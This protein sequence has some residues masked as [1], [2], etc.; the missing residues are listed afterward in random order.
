MSARIVWAVVGGFLM[1]VFAASFFSLGYTFALFALLLATLAGLFV[2]V[3]TE[4]RNA[5]IVAVVV[6]IAFAAGT[7]RM[8]G[9]VR[10]EDATLSSHL[11]E[12]VT[13]SGIVSQ[14][15][16]KRE[17]NTRLTIDVDTM[18]Y[19]S[20]ESEVDAKILVIAPLRTEAK[21]GDTVEV[22]GELDRPEAF[23][24]TLG[25]S[26]DYPKYLAK[27]GILYTLSFA[28]VELL[29]ENYANPAKAFAIGIKQLFL[30]GL[31]ASIPEPEAGLAGGITVGDKRSIGEELTDDFIATS[32]IH[33]VVLSGYN[34]TIV[35]NSVNAFA[36]HAPSSAR[37]GIAGVI[38]ALFALMSG[39]AATAV[40]AGA[41]ALIAIYAR[42][43][44]RTFLA[45]RALGVVCMAMV[46]WNPWTLAFDPSFQLSALATLGLIL[47]T[48]IFAS[49]LHRVPKRWGMREILAST[50]ATQIAV[51]P[52]LLYQSGTLSLVGLPAN[53]LALITVPTA[54]G[55]SA[56]AAVAGLIAGPLAPIIGFPAYLVLGYEI[57]VAQFFAS[58]PF[59]SVDIPAFG[60]LWLFAAYALLFAGYAYLKTKT[61]PLEGGVVEEANVSA[62]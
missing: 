48:P 61:T 62:R 10:V 29:G 37:F 59:A 32:L 45:A 23:D 54:M 12:K 3:N 35:I 36:A 25:R 26:F 7:A 39:G 40:R 31:G 42:T 18:I 11:G 24:T 27:D 22:T 28:Q 46:L 49:W 16:D 5:L 60:P 43:T 58:L 56:V 4:K 33:M 15:P 9:A 55:A 53:L 44:H 57:A 6:C 34:I 1:G 51:L 14:E 8:E 17:S 50:I 38:V 19:H 47:F 30:K 2:L 52:L 20:V 41:M 21:Y 13:L